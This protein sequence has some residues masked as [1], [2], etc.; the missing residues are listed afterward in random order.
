MDN[1]C[2][3]YKSSVSNFNSPTFICSFY[4][5]FKKCFNFSVI[6]FPKLSISWN[7]IFECPL[8]FKYIFKFLI[9]RIPDYN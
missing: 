5:R 6:H 8:T 4:F 7:L 1:L 9:L 2:M 3:K